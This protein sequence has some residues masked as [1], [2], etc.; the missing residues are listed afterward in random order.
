MF[1][2]L[3]FFKIETYSRMAT[4]PFWGSWKITEVTPYSSHPEV[5]ILEGVE[6]N[7]KEDGDVIWK[8]PEHRER[9]PLLECDT[10]EV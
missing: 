2:F 5:L 3:L 7:L 1:Q 10:Y 6:F 8:Y 4:E 9:L